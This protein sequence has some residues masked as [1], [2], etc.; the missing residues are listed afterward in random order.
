MSIHKL[1][2]VTLDFYKEAYKHELSKFELPLEQ[3]KYTS[4]PLEA[5]ALCEKEM[6]RHPI[7]ILYK[8]EPAGFFVL[9][10]WEGVR[11]FSENKKAILFRAYSINSTF[12]G[13]GIAT[14]SMKVLDV[15][16]KKY[17]P[18]K[19]EIILAVNHA[20]TVAQY[21]YKKAGFIDKGVRAMGGQ[22][23]M[24]ILHKAL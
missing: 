10:G 5:I 12:Q 8:G 18:D 7:V 9:N 1:S 14:E 21:V 20:N 4:L 6:D 3:L 24:F 2:T 19:D 23:E 13:K 17:F 11:A 22:G 15:F 16:V